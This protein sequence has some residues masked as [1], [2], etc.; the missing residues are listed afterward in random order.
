MRSVLGLVSLVIQ[1]L[2]GVQ[3]KEQLLAGD[4][5]GRTALMMAAAQHYSAEKKAR[6]IRLHLGQPWRVKMLLAVDKCVHELPV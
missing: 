5:D 6:I 2:T 3:R 1:V 4:C